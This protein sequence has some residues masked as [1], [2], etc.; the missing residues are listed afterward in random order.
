MSDA[1][2]HT[3]P[4]VYHRLCAD[5]SLELRPRILSK[6][7]LTELSHVLENAVITHD[8]PGAVFTGFQE[9]RHWFRELARYQRLVEPKAR[10]VA[11]FAAG[12]LDSI[13]E[14]GIVR[15][16]L[17]E[18]S[19][20]VEEWFLI[21]LT[22]GFS[23]A[24]LGE[25]V[26]PAP[27]AAPADP[28]AAAP[29]DPAPVDELDRRFE[30][31][32]TFDAPT[33][34]TITRAIRDEVATFDTEVAG[35]I[36]AALATF[37]PGPESQ[38]LRDEVVGDLVTALERS[39]ERFRAAAL[40]EE[41]RATTLDELDRSKSAFLSA[42]SHELRT[43][44]TV[45][46]GMAATLQRLG[47]ELADGDRDRL[48]SALTT[49]AD[50]LAGLLDDLLDL[51]RLT[52]GALPT[53]WD[54][55]DAV[56]VTR[57]ALGSCAGAERMRL[58]AP[59]SHPVT[60]DRTQFERIVVN[61]AENANKYAPAGPIE[62]ALGPHEDGGGIVLTVDDQGPGVP[63]TDRERIFEPFHRLDDD[64]HSPG[65]G[66]GLALVAEFVRVHHGD[67]EVTDSPSGGARFVVT[68]PGWRGRAGQGDAP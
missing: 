44:L 60:M 10:S 33:I 65:T 32:W 45:I 31:V 57:V 52:R 6:A 13:S 59:V 2:A 48:Q 18:D 55:I 62:V 25:E 20:L 49:N 24:L 46:R 56:E 17:A 50:R 35:R 30:V 14:D 29:A 9:S 22:T 11:V 5:P 19:P 54:L 42:V 41:Q 12:N 37:P 43:P 61:L 66:I 27:Q 58:T 16:R 26:D 8:L 51:D 64:H 47:P 39:R 1:P 34:T 67:I 15:V 38:S 53:S 23:A 28:G 40:R 4:R 3:R 7:T 36:D 21:V 63:L 68:I